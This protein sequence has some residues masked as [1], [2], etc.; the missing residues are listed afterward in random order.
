MSNKVKVVVELELDLATIAMNKRTV[1]SNIPGISIPD[2]KSLKD[3][4]EPHLKDN[5]L[6]FAPFPISACPYCGSS[7]CIALDGYGICG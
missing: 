4:I 1:Y 2:G 6:D 3:L 7:D 5:G